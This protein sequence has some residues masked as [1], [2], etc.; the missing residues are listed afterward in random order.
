MRRNAF[1]LV[2]TFTA[3][4]TLGLF[5]W[6]GHTPEA[7]AFHDAQ[8]GRTIT[9]YRFTEDRAAGNEIRMRE[10]VAYELP[11]D[12]FDGFGGEPVRDSRRTP[13]TPMDGLGYPLL[14]DVRRGEVLLA[15]HFIDFER[16]RNRNLPEQGER[17]IAVSIQTEQQ[18]ANMQPGDRV[19]LLGAVPLEG[20]GH[21]YIAIL[22]DAEVVA[23]TSPRAARHER[24]AA[25]TYLT[26]SLSSEQ[27]LQL[28]A[29]RDRIQGDSF[30][31]ALRPP[32]EPGDDAD[33]QLTE[34]ALELLR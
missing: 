23:L 9:V 25:G 4:L 28:F 33:P 13:G 34:R 19:D 2:I 1:C 8:D 18:P 26:L 27:S 14:R 30:I 22:E 31:V 6:P 24:E 20:G 10:L 17:Q 5:L 16:A 21:Q 15:E 29:I 11:A 7:V 3:V 12:L 32:A